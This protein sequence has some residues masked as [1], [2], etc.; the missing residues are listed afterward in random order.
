[1][2]SDFPIDELE[3]LRVLRSTSR[4]L[5]T[6]RTKAEVAQVIV[7]EAHRL[8]GAAASVVYEC[9]GQGL[10]TLEASCGIPEPVQAALRSIPRD[11]P[12]PLG[13]AVCRR[14]PV[15]IESR[16]AL[17]AAYPHVT[18]SKVPSERVH[19]VAA[20]PLL[21]DGEAIGGMAL[22]FAND[23]VF[24]LADRELLEAV[25]DHCAHGF[26]RARSFAAAERELTRSAL[27]ARVSHML[28]AGGM[29]DEALT[30]VS[31]LV[32][33]TVG[34]ECTFVLVQEN[35][36]IY[37]VPHAIDDRSMTDVRR[38][39][40]NGEP[41]LRHVGD[42]AQGGWYAI[43]PI[44]T[45][46][47]MAGA[48]RLVSLVPESSLEFHSALAWDIATRVGLALERTW[49]RRA[50]EEGEPGSFVDDDVTERR[51]LDYLEA[52][53]AEQVELRTVTCDGVP[54]TVAATGTSEVLVTAP[55]AEALRRAGA[56]D[57]RHCAGE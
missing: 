12:L 24:S 7:R 37:P 10:M 41:V 51:V 15:W 20:L 43:A 47:G 25:A 29:E 3:R 39:L 14:E 42:G 6:S 31:T 11:I 30:A 56:R 33:D 40:M 55:T 17:L 46:D 26:V 8:L 52:E 57:L 21:M 54:H 50:A 38:V 23:R 36:R 9:N 53:R 2:L 48:L 18:G 34:L 4:G 32:A 22:S 27:L 16:D 35:G 19:A 13:T 49:A 5:A 28:D 44:R 45:S 1:M